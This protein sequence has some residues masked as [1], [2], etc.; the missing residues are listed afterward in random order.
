LAIPWRRL[1]IPWAIQ[2]SDHLPF[3]LVGFKEA[4]SLSMLP[5]DC[6]SMLEERL[7]STTTAGLLAGRRPE[8]P[9]PFSVFHTEEDTSVRLSEEPLRMML[10]VVRELAGGDKTDSSI[11]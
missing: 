6:I 7:D 9:E 8:L 2:S 5:G 1:D 10:T 11:G 4:I 3:K